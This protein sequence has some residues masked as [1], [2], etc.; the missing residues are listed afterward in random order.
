MGPVSELIPALASS[1]PPSLAPPG[2][3]SL[4]LGALPNRRNDK[5][6]LATGANF[7]TSIENN[8]F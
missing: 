8:E 6:T 1:A 5:N 3:S 7:I 4:P 2:E